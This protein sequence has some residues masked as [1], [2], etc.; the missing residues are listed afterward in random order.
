MRKSLVFVVALSLMA[1]GCAWFTSSEESETVTPAAP[2]EEVAAPAPAPA[3][4]AA[5]A[6]AQSSAKKATKAAA[7]TAAKKGAKSEAQIKAELDKMGQKLV[8][9]SKRT[10]LPNKA[11]KEVKKVG[12]EYVAT[13]LEVDTNNVSTEMKPGANGQY[14][15]FIRYQE[16]VFEC[17]GATRQ[18]ALSAPCTQVRARN[19]N[20][21]IRYDGKEWQ[22]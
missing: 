2:A 5:K 19:L 10:L 20:E 21:L 3:A 8:N 16:R 6:P 22:D 13:Y 4:E 11:N 17:R 1:G 9:Q 14:V 18:A 15:G 12:G 7:K